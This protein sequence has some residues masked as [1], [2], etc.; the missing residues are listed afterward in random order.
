MPK[1][2]TRVMFK[3]LGCLC[4]NIRTIEAAVKMMTGFGCS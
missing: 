2:N 1:K 3:A 4:R